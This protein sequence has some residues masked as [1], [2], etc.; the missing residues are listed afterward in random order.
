MS[1][2]EILVDTNILIY[3]L[4]GDL[5]IKEVLNEKHI[6]I[7]FITEL[8]LIGFK[9]IPSK[10]EKLLRDLLNECIVL[11]LNEKIKNNYVSLRKNYSLKLADSIIV[12]TSLAVNIPLFSADKQLRQIKELDLLL[13]H[14]K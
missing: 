14:N 13:F 4:N 5:T 8:E 2:K 7:S 9:N 3:F 1:G 10:Q 12:A 11:P 6:Y